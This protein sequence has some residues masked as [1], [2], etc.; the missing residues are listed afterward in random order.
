M[1]TSCS[2]DQDTSFPA[3][4]LMDLD[5]SFPV[6]S[7]GSPTSPFAFHPPP[8]SPSNTVTP[9]GTPAAPFTTITPSTPPALGHPSFPPSHFASLPPS[10]PIYSPALPLGADVTLLLPPLRGPLLG[11]LIDSRQQVLLL[12][13]HALTP[14]MGLEGKAGRGEQHLYSHLALSCQEALEKVNEWLR[15]SDAQGDWGT[16]AQAEERKAGV[17]R[18]LDLELYLICQHVT[19]QSTL[20][21]STLQRLW[22]FYETLRQ[23]SSRRILPPPSSIPTTNTTPSSFCSAPTLAAQLIRTLPAGTILHP[24]TTPQS[25]TRLLLHGCLLDPALLELARDKKLGVDVHGWEGEEPDDVELAL[26]KLGLGALVW[27]GRKG[28]RGLGEGQGRRELGT[29]VSPKVAV[30]SN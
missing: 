27:G 28:A 17:V 7:P 24:S 2:M 13:A 19:S 23:I 25:T 6:D 5:T 20:T 3:S 26:R 10:T 12:A 16:A 9:G 11:T 29:P 15:E 8:L 30:F 14:P 22:A 1:D 4:C 21:A 18:V